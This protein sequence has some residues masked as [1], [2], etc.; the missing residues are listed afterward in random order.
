MFKDQDIER[1]V[2]CSLK[3]TIINNIKFAQADVKG[4]GRC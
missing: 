4:D 2:E 3:R 1:E